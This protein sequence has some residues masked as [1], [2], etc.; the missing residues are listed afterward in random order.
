M[1][2]DPEKYTVVVARNVI[3]DER[4]KEKQEL[5]YIERS[6]NENEQEK[7]GEE[8]QNDKEEDFNRS[9][10]IGNQEGEN[11]KTRTR[12]KPKWH[13]DYEMNFDIEEDE[14]LFALHVG[15]TDNVPL[16]YEDEALFALH[17]G[18]TDNVPLNYEDL[19]LRKDREEWMN[20][21]KEEV[22]VL[23]E[24]NTWEV[25]PQPKN[26]KLIDTKWV[27]TKKELHGSTM[28]KARLVALG[29]QQQEDF[30]DIYSPVL[31]MQTLRILLS[32]A[33]YR[34]YQIHQMDVKGAFLYGEIKDNVFLKPPKGIKIENGYALRL[35][36]AL[37]GLKKSPKH[38]YERFTEIITG[39]G[40][41]RSENDYCLY[42]GFGFKRSENDYCLYYKNDLYILLYVD[43]LLILGNDS[44]EIRKV[45]DFLSS[46][47]RM[48]DMGKDNL[49]YLGISINKQQDCITIDQTKYLRNILKRFGMSEC[50]RIETPMDANFK[51]DEN[52]I[53]DPSY[54]NQCRSLIGSL[55]Y[56]TVASRPDLAA[57]V[58]Y[59]S[60]FQS[61]P[62]YA[63]VASRPDLA[64]SVYYLSRFQSR[65]SV[66]LW[67]ALK[68]ILRYIKAT[69]D[70]QLLYTKDVSSSALVG[71][72][73]ADWARD[74]DRKSTSG[75]LFKVYGNTVIW[76]S[77]TTSGYL[78]KVYGNTVIWRSK[79]Q[80]TVALSTTE[81]E[82]VSLCEASVEACWVRKL[83]L[84]LSVDTGIINIF[85]DNQSTIK[86]V[87]NP[88]QKRLKHMEVKLNFI[89]QK[90][91]QG[92]IKV[93]YISSREQ[94]ADVFTKPL[95]KTL[96]KY[97]IVNLGLCNKNTNVEEE[98]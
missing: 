94:L 83:L 78:F 89:K 71:Y 31:R 86:S 49:L 92:I 39:F 21:M 6:Q 16:N 34:E 40:F 12:N 3:F 8:A 79:K 26:E 38:W 58:Y 24:R 11:S 70:Y 90:V 15:Q 29:F 88:D 10:E 47:F 63:T 50:N 76:R 5:V 68:R 32:V 17:V 84:E 52:C 45:K 9:V 74:N 97:C 43:D 51:L 65:P 18:Q 27:F 75:Y 81:A 96:F 54:E 72:A 77:K 53:V 48:K 19:K 56:A 64:A 28:Y 46:Q 14:A 67:K 2:W 69:I 37:Y 13:D 23:K 20:A 44:R 95:C 66:E 59:L 62:M 91:E 35:K 33:V 30:S 60:R 93:E 82:Y 25:V 4:P 57:S 1:G 73:D 22:E 55:M 36:K 80:S 61:R 87:K 85:E 42:T 41:K 98:C 7:C